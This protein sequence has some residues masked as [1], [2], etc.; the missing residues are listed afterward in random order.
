MRR[1]QV[2]VMGVSGSG[3]STVGEQV[4]ELLGVPF[5]DGDALHPAANVAKMASG[6]PL[7]D[8]DRIPWLR[9]VGRA[10]AETS[11]EG[12]VVACSALK[13]S[14]RDLIRSE[15]PDALF[16]ELDGDRAL[17]A[18]RMAARPGHFMPVSLLDSQLA[19]LEPLQ[20]EEHG[21]RLDVSRSPAELADAIAG[22]VR[23]AA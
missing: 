11:P 7:T 5:V 4:A 6:V 23:A 19:T 10:L 3:K 16:A 12:A 8:D 14:Y 21:L 15:A 1:P 9:A 13:R 20:P 17:L 18:A 22:A 2:V